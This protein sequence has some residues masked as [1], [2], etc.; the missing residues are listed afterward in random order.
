MK[1]DFLSGQR[2]SCASFEN[3]CITGCSRNWNSCILRL[4]W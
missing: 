1:R 3:T 4:L 2:D